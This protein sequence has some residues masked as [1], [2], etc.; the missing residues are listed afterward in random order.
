M[1]TLEHRQ[2]RELMHDLLRQIPAATRPPEAD[3]EKTVIKIV[4]ALA[5]PPDNPFVRCDFN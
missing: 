1:M 3:I 4:E 2:V 5:E